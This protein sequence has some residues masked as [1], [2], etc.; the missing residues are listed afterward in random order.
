MLL[1]LMGYDYDYFKFISNIC[2]INIGK[3]YFARKR[4]KIK[5]SYKKGKKCQ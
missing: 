2:D 5:K 1:N 3:P 4:K